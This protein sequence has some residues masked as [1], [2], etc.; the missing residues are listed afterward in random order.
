MILRVSASIASSSTK[1]AR[2]TQLAAEEQ[3]LRGVEVVGQRQRLVDRLDAVAAC[4]AGRADLD[5]LAVDEDLAAVGVVGAGEHLDQRRL[6]GAVVA[7]QAD[8][9]ARVEVDA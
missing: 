7:E 1:P 2:V 4:V 3:V 6:A 8:H 9:L 5:L